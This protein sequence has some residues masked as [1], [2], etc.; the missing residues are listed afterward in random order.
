MHLS[1]PFNIPATVCRIASAIFTRKIAPLITYHNLNS[2]LFLN[3]SEMYSTRLGDVISF[4]RYDR[5][6]AR[7]PNL[8][9]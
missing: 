2:R 5:A 4:T 7:L 3:L 6:F 8:I 1:M 9:T